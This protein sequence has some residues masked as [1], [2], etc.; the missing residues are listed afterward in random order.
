M[1]NPFEI[2]N[3]FPVT[4][5]SEVIDLESSFNLSSLNAF[6][7][8]NKFEESLIELYDNDNKFTL[9]TL[10]YFIFYVISLVSG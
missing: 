9:A 3:L 8:T 6:K 5:R 2:N 10:I 7:R 1:G 4:I